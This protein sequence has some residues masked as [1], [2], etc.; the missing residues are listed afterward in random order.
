[1]F[2][3]AVLTVALISAFYALPA[4]AQNAATN[5]DPHFAAALELMDATNAKANMLT[6]ID[7]IVP[8]MLNQI[9]VLRPNVS[10]DALQE[11]RTA[12]REELEGDLDGVMKDYAR[13]YEEHFTESDLRALL[14]FYR[15]D[16]GKKYIDAMPA[17][18]K[19]TAPIGAAWGREAGMRAAQRAIERLHAK[20]IDL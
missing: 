17:L 13:L 15:S 19:E 3:A 4:D 5:D 6:I 8:L 16:V 20:G 11:F 10:A 14:Q 9:R 1:M 18:L 2:R 12:I 7:T